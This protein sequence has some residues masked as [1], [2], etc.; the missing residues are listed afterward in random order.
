MTTRE[1]WIVYPLLF[2]ALGIALRDKLIPPTLIEAEQIRC[3]RLETEETACQSLSVTSPG[4]RELIHLGTA[5]NGMGRFE[6][7]GVDGATV[8]AVGTDPAGRSGVVETLAHGGIAQ[9]QLRST[10]RGGAVAVIDREG[11]GSQVWTIGIADG[12][13]KDEPQDLWETILRWRR[14]RVPPSDN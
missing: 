3:D 5:A 9:V 12:T 11:S 14:H 8:V 7:R 1:R 10:A 4:N 13:S 2:L 6:L